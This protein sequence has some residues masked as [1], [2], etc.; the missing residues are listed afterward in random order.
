MEKAIS[1]AGVQAYL[2]GSGVAGTLLLAPFLGR[3]VLQ[4]CVPAAAPLVYVPFFVLPIVWGVWNWLRLR[5][6]SGLTVGVWGAL[7]GVVV[8]LL[9]NLLLAAE[10][11]WFSGAM[12]LPIILP[13][14]YAALWTFVVG[15]LNRALGVE[16]YATPSP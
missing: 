14:V 9:A 11:R 8:G 15:P 1:R 4:M 10:Q 12:L 16:T 3:S 6:R 13:F 2:I 7:L 5:L